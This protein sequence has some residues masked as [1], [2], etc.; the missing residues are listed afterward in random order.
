MPDK[1]LTWKNSK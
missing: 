1:V